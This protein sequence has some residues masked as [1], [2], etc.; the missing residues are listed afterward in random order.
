[1]LRPVL[2]LSMLL[3][4]GIRCGLLMGLHL[5][6][7][8]CLGLGMMLV[9]AGDG[10]AIAHAGD[11]VGVDGE[12]RDVFVIIPLVVISVVFESFRQP[13]GELILGWVHS[14]AVNELPTATPEAAPE[15]DLPSSWA[16]KRGWRGVADGDGGRR[17]WWRGL[18]GIG[19]FVGWFLGVIA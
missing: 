16:L 11:V 18:L 9:R 7:S 8:L 12:C 2:V 14:P 10:R 17:V 5:S 3:V 6:T 4:L 13:E 19:S 1:L 15:G